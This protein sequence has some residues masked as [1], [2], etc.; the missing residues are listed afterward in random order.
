MTKY[1]VSIPLVGKAVFEVEAESPSEAKD[2]AFDMDIEE[3]DALLE[4]ELVP[5]VV[6][7]NIFHGSLNRVNVEKVR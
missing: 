1:Y 2:I 6:T 3:D 7:G 4:Y 5:E